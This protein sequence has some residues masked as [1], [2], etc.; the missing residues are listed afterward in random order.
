M[1]Q[2]YDELY[3]LGSVHECVLMSFRPLSVGKLL[4][5]CLMTCNDHVT[6]PKNVLLKPM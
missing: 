6:D 4:E 5:M 2:T 1:S 3:S